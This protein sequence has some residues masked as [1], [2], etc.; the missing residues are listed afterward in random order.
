MQR[1]DFIKPGIAI[2]LCIEDVGSDQ[3]RPIGGDLCHQLCHIA[4]G[5]GPATQL[6]DAGVIN[7][8]N[9]NRCLRLLGPQPGTQIVTLM[10]KQLQRPP[11]CGNCT[12]QN[13]GQQCG[14][15]PV[16]LRYFG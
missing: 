4:P 3:G 11:L 7:S 6:G 16:G 10:L 12:D 5:P 8:H 15:Q 13:Q 2:R 9:H 14:N 1:L